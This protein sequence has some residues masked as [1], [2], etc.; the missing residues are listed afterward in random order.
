MWD[1]KE[2]TRWDSQQIRDNDETGKEFACM[3]CTAASQLKST[4]AKT[5]LLP[6]TVWVSN[7]YNSNYMMRHHHRK[8]FP[9]SFPNKEGSNTVY[10]EST[11]AHVEKHY[12][13]PEIKMVHVNK[14][15]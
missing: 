13:K 8:I 7:Q 12:W 11:L 14:K 1:H 6:C 10:V 9:S 4:K 5:E 15:D 2:A 3:L